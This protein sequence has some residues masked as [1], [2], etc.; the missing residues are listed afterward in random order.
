MKALA[1]IA[2][3]MILIVAA[4]GSSDD[5]ALTADE[6]LAVGDAYFAALD[7][8]D[9]DAAR[10]LFASDAT[11]IGSLNLEVFFEEWELIGAWDQ[12]QRAVRTVEGCVADQPDGAP[13]TVTCEWT[14]HQYIAQ[15]VGAPPVAWTTTI[16]FDEDGRISAF[17]EDFGQPDYSTVNGPF[18]IWMRASHPEDATKVDCCGGDTVEESITRGTLRAAY[19]D[20]WVAYLD[21]NGC[22][23]TEGC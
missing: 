2:A 12:A 10:G 13:I 11:V 17:S 9:V 1:P 21:A 16:R 23:Y 20:E 18:N 6:A 5:D 15:A 3:V 19:A 4:C 8:T 7:A 14:D 22:T